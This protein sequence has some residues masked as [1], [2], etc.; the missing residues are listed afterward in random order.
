MIKAIQRWWYSSKLLKV[1]QAFKQGKIKRE[2]WSQKIDSY[3]KKLDQ[4]EK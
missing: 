4:L 3:L 1:D 2:E